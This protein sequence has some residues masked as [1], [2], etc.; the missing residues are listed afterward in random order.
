MTGVSS[1]DLSVILIEE[2]T[3]MVAGETNINN[4]VFE[5]EEDSND[6]CTKNVNFSDFC[7][8]DLFLL[9]S[10]YIL[11]ENVMSLLVF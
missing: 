1:R 2:H 7:I 11:R 5:C 10:N 6:L 8:L 3:E 4:S 9:F